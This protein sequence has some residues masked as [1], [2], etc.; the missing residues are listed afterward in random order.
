LDGTIKLGVQKK[1]GTKNYFIIDGD[2]FEPAYNGDNTPYHM[3]F[4]RKDEYVGFA[5]KLTDV[6]NPKRPAA[7]DRSE[8][9]LMDDIWAGAPFKDRAAFIKKVQEVTKTYQDEGLL[10]SRDRQVVLLASARAKMS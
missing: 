6:L 3:Y 8:S 5:G 2:E 9:T 4:Q 1:E 7:Q 10:S